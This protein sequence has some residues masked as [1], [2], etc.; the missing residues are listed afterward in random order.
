MIGCFT[1]RMAGVNTFGLVTYNLHGL[2]SGRA[3]LFELC[4]NSQVHVIAVQE[5]WLSNSNLHLLND[6]H[7]DFVGFGISS[8]TNRLCT[9][10]YRGRP[11]GGVGFLWRKS[12]SDKIGIGA[13]APSGRILSISLSLDS[14]EV[15][16]IVTVYLPVF[17]SN[18]NYA[19]EL[20]ECVGFIENIINDG[21]SVVILGDMNF[22][23]DDSN[24]GFKSF[25][26]TLS[27]YNIRHCDEYIDTGNCVTYHNPYLNQSSFIDHVF[28]SNSIRLD[29]LNAE[30]QDS[31]INLS[32]HIPIIYHFNWSLNNS[33]GCKKPSRQPTKQYSWRWD[34]SFLPRYYELSDL[35][36]RNVVV[37]NL[38]NCCLG[39]SCNTHCASINIYYEN[40]VAALHQAACKSIRRVPCHSLK[41]YWN[42]E[43]DNLKN[44]SIFWH[45]LWTD[46]GR[47]SSGVLQRIRLSCK[48]K[49]KLAIRNAYTSFEGTLSDELYVHFLNK[50]IPDFWKVWNAKF[51]KHI[52]KGVIINS[53]VDDTDV[54]NEFAQHFKN[55]FYNSYDDETACR[56]Y[57]TKR[58][59]CLGNNLQTSY[60]CIDRIT[61]EL[62]EK[63][64]L[65]LKKGKA[66][67]PDDLCAE[68]I[69][70]AHPSLLIHLKNLFKFIMLHRFVPNSFG[71]GVVIPLIK[72]K[73]GNLNGVDNYRPITLSPIISKLFEAVLLTLCDDALATDP[74]QFG[75]KNNIGCADAIFTL[76][77]TVEYFVDRGSSVFVASLDISKAFD[78]VNHFKLYNSLLSAGVPL[79]IVDVL[80][81]W[82]SKLFC[83]VRWNNHLS[84]QFPVCSGVRQGSCL[85]PAV[86]N[87]FMNVFIVKLKL[88]DIGC[89]VASLYLGCLLYADDLILLS[90]TVTGLQ[91]MLDKCSE[92]ADALS[93]RFNVNKSHC[94]VFGSMYKMNIN[95]LMLGNSYINWSD[96]IRY[97][98]VYLLRGK[99]LKFDMNPIKRK[100][101]A[102]CNSIFMHGA[103]VDEIAL[104]TL[105]ESYSQSI[106]MYAAQAITFT[107]KQVDEINACWNSVIRRLFGFGKFESVKAVLFGLGRLNIRHLILQRKVTFYRHMFRNNETLH[108]IFCAFLL[109]NSRNDDV[110]KTVFL[111]VSDAVKGIWSSF[112]AYDNV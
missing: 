61:V 111:T 63:C 86:F 87:V 102:A 106:L 104:L 37:P 41:P 40:I 58:L 3:G 29:I 55:V 107:S 23:C 93:L 94:I 57:S 16:N 13:K 28:V 89:H 17:S 39:C 18:S 7:P 81:N 52:S 76:K 109:H 110:F 5:H 56:D 46:A 48:A 88:A 32:D 99:L 100:F 21:R 96:S 77:S 51:R 43:L 62:I 71:T 90:P 103:G 47:P 105:Q 45:N 66:C 95:Q 98:G 27:E 24:D 64:R 80:S 73:A 31:G 26:S 49:Y 53:K 9:E 70:F 54:A 83:A 19:L 22:Q 8:M 82:Y 75:F 44:D 36:L 69:H 91:C 30:V 38:H 97:L 14:T 1:I 15:I 67:G 112:T 10:V 84:V 34:R 101:Y 78:R 68:N 65:G 33:V 108:D 25:S 4:C 2:N 50:N 35:E 20:A 11:Y 42:D 74:L 79:I 59:E 6:I 72:D 85:S 92:L 12:C 60:D